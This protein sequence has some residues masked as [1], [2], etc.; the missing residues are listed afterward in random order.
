[1][2]AT[3]VMDGVHDDLPRVS[4]LLSASLG[5]AP[6]P[7]P[8]D[9]LRM[10]WPPSPQYREVTPGEG[11]PMNE[12]M[13]ISELDLRRLLGIATGHRDE[14]AAEGLP[15]AQLSE[16]T[17]LI[18]CDEA[19]FFTLDS[20]TRAGNTMQS[21]PPQNG[22]P[23]SGPCWGGR[24]SPVRTRTAAA[25]CAASPGCRT[26]TRPGSGTGAACTATTSG[27]P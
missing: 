23:S 22:S 7:P 8:C 11:Q 27:P 1:M 5:R 16:L 21:I 24:D 14:S 15:A 12:R 3:L 18:R 19:S 9:V 4:P 25:T 26:S 17:G 13:T 10:V 6:G 20:R 2:A